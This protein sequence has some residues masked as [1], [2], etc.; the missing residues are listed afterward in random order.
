MKFEF[1]TEKEYL[2]E[3]IITLVDPYISTL[4]KYSRYHV[5]ADAEE[6]LEEIKKELNE[7]LTSESEQV[8]IIIERGKLNGKRKH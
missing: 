6:M 3:E 8:I 5:G 1:D 2:V 4:C 7:L